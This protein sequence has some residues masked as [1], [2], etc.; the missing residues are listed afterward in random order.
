MLRATHVVG[1]WRGALELVGK[2]EVPCGVEPGGVGMG[3][4]VVA[5]P[6]A[7]AAA[8]AFRKPGDCLRDNTW[9]G[10]EY[11]GELSQL[12][13]RYN[14]DMVRWTLD[15]ESQCVTGSSM[16][17]SAGAATEYSPQ[18]TPESANLPHP[19]NRLPSMTPAF[20][21]REGTNRTAVNWRH[22][23]LARRTL[24]RQGQWLTSLSPSTR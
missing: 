9:K 23:D 15:D 6:V 11:S 8:G 20:S 7:P 5:A 14:S 2:V 21:T 18:C 22:V 19:T 3:E 12:N 13:G 16:E 24:G 1:V 4:T 10:R 17:Y